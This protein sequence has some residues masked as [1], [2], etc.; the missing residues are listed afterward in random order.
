M[1]PQ[2]GSSARPRPGR[3]NHSI[4]HSEPP[5]GR[6]LVDIRLRLAVAMAVVYVT[7]AALKAQDA[8]SDADAA[9][10]LQRSVGDELD[11]QIERLDALAIRCGE[12]KS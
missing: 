4:S 11:R 1:S 9:L 12:R 2:R 8:D 5:I 6:V 3:N 10:V 7:S